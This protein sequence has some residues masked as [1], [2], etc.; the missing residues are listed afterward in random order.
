MKAIGSSFAFSFFWVRMEAIV[1]SKAKEYN[2]KYF[3]KLR[4]IRTGEVV[5]V[6]LI[7]VK[8]F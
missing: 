2:I 8:S 6:R 7:S 5:I 3:S 1:S 4:L